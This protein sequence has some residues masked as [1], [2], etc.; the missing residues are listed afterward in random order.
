MDLVCSPCIF[1]LVDDWAAFSDEYVIVD[2]EYE[3]VGR[4]VLNGQNLN[5][6]LEEKLNEKPPRK[7]T[8]TNAAAVASRTAAVDVAVRPMPP[9]APVQIAATAA[10]SNDKAHYVAASSPPKA[11]QSTDGDAHGIVDAVVDTSTPNSFHGDDAKPSARGIN[12]GIDDGGAIE[13][14]TTKTEN[15]LVGERKEWV[16]DDNSLEEL[17]GICYKSFSCGSV[18]LFV[19]TPFGDY[20]AFHEGC[21]HYY[22]SMESIAASKRDGR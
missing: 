7:V 18:G 19:P 8:N 1:V 15:W 14:L 20:I 3:D 9:A 22:L 10:S 5:V 16:T 13:E 4:K 6:E 17:L 21:P 11:A 2:S 12:G